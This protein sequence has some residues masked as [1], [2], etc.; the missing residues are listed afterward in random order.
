MHQERPPNQD[1]YKSPAGF[2]DPE[3]YLFGKAHTAKMAHLA[4]TSTSVWRSVEYAVLM[5]MFYQAWHSAM[6][7]DLTSRQREAWHLRGEAIRLNLNPAQHVSDRLGIAKVSAYQLLA[8]TRAKIHNFN[9]FFAI[10]HEDQSRIPKA[11]QAQVN[12]QL[13]EMTVRCACDGADNCQGSAPARY[14]I[15]WHCKQRYGYPHT[16]TDLTASWLPEHVNHVRREAYARAKAI[17]ERRL[18]ESAPT[19]RDIRQAI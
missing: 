17:V 19:T 11:T 5:R 1:W 2:L 10:Y 8:R 14:G 9:Q 12:A 4:F 18:I 3:D 6:T 7:A 13:C 15:C 16:M